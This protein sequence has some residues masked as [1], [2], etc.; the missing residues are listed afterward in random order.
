[1]KKE[2]VI[3]INLRAL[4]IFAIA[5]IF[6]ELGALLTLTIP[7]PQVRGAHQHT[8]SRNGTRSRITRSCAPY[9]TN[10]SA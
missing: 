10:C 2:N 6:Y 8:S 7:S 9:R 5:V 1:M 4:G 3:M